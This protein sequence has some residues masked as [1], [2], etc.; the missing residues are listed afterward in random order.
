MSAVGK[1][2]AARLSRLTA[3]AIALAESFERLPEGSSL[4]DEALIETRAAHAKMVA[5][6]E[7]LQAHKEELDAE[8]EEVDGWA[9]EA[10]SVASALDDMIAGFQE[11]EEIE[12]EGEGEE[13][14]GEDV[15]A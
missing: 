6:V 12:D 1:R 10:E 13:D 14:G 3:D 15:P 8:V 4:T 2:F 7:R 11:G 5:L 9:S